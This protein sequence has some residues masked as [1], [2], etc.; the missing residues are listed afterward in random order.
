MRRTG[1]T[2]K[3]LFKVSMKKNRRGC[4]TAEALRA[5]RMLRDRH[6]MN[7]GGRGTRPE[8]VPYDEIVREQ[9]K[10]IDELM[11]RIAKLGGG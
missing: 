3:E 9:W 4:A 2:D 10:V 5:Q 1:K 8:G 7:W 6:N 11:S